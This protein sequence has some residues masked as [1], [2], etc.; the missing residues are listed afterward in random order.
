M[1]LLVFIVFGKSLDMPNI[2]Q[3]LAKI[4]DCI[5]QKIT[6]CHIYCAFL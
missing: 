1:F 5:N 3:E 2:R 6:R 4:E